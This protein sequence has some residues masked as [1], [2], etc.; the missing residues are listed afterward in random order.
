MPAVK[1]PNQNEAFVPASADIEAA[2]A[3]LAA[4]GIEAGNDTAEVVARRTAIEAQAA[5]LRS[6]A[7]VDATVC[8]LLDAIIAA[9]FDA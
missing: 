5:A 3:T 7:V 4:A 8:D 1:P 2:Q 9:V 6:S